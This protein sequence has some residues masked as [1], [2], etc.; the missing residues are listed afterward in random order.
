MAIGLP[1]AQAVGRLRC[2]AQGCCH[3][4]ACD[5]G[6]VGLRYRN[7]LSRVKQ[8]E[9]PAERDLKPAPVVSIAF[10]LL[11]GAALARA[12]LDGLDVVVILSA[13]LILTGLSRFV[14]EGMRGEPQT[15]VWRGLSLYQWLC[16]G[17]VSAGM[18]VTFLPGAGAL[19]GPALPGLGGVAIAASISMLWVVG[20]SVDWPWTGWRFSRLAPLDG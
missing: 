16:V 13:Y 17:L 19:S 18:P 1:F 12:A 20:L 4:S 3:G 9:W 11:I 5:H 14:E 10:N 7:P 15:P 6:G 2:L 8:I